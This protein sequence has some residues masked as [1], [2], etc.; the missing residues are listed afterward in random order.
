MLYIYQL[1]G[2]QKL[3]IKKCKFNFI[4]YGVS[5][6]TGLV[7]NIHNEFSRRSESNNNQWFGNDKIFGIG[8]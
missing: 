3:L 5:G 1:N 2:Y 6:T 4:R 8:I 7:K